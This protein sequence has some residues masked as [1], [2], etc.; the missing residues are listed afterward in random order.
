MTITH[1]DDYDEVLSRIEGREEL[2]GRF[3]AVKDWTDKNA[4]KPNRKGL[5]CGQPMTEE[6][7][8]RKHER[9]REYMRK[10]RAAWVA[11]GLTTLGKP[12]IN[13]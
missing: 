9:M 12:R 13:L 6:Q 10:R 2:T 1:W 7:R 11:K 8:K 3:L 5:S 4:A